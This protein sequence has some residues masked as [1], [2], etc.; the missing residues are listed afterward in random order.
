MKSNDIH[1]HHTGF[2]VDDIDK[3]AAKMIFEER[4]ADVVDPIQNARLVLFKN[5]SNVYI[6]LIQPL[7]QYSFTWKSLQK[8]GNHFNHFC[9]EVADKFILDDFAKKFKLIP[10][11][12]PLPALLFANR[13]VVFYYTRNKEIVEFII[14][15]DEN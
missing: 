3:F 15:G 1:L 14:I 2:I 5:F 7:N 9:Y 12:E 11:T 6:E 13:M 4:V 10:V 8:N